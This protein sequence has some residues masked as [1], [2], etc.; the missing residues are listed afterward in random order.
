MITYK[1]EKMENIKSLPPQSD[2]MNISNYGRRKKIPFNV[3]AWLNKELRD[4][5]FYKMKVKHNNYKKF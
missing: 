1:K 5:M 3:R 2:Q 4:V